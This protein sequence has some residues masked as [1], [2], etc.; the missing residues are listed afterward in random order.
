MMLQPEERAKRQR[1]ISKNVAA[2]IFRSL[3]VLMNRSGVSELAR[4][5]IFERLTSLLLDKHGTI[6]DP[7][8]PESSGVHVISSELPFQVFPDT[9]ETTSPTSFNCFISMRDTSELEFPQE[10]NKVAW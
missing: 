3:D 5:Q 4:N 8:V 2:S 9:L 10:V 1:F 6:Y 7:D